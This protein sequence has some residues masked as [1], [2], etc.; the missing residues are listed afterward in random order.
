MYLKLPDTMIRLYI[1]ANLKFQTSI[2]FF[3]ALAGLEMI[4]RNTNLQ[5]RE[6]SPF[7]PP[8][9]SK[10]I[11]AMELILSHIIKGLYVT[12]YDKF[13]TPM[14]FYMAVTWSQSWFRGPNLRFRALLPF[15]KVQI[16]EIL[17]YI[18]DIF[19]CCEG[20]IS[21]CIPQI[22]DHYLLFLVNYRISK[23]ASELG[24]NTI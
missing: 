5:C 18:Y 8:H 4:A 23:L 11:Q 6:L 24:E 16:S 14:S 15:S 17:S 2:S 20:A 19:R 3:M 21:V 13:Q 1:S 12:V 7:S 9:N 22:L 10:S